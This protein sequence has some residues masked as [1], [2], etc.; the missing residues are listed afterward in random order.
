MNELPDPRVLDELVLQPSLQTRSRERYRRALLTTSTIV[1]ARGVAALTSLVTVPLTLGYL[2]AE[3][4][5]LWMTIASLISF[6]I[7]TDLGLGNSLLTAIAKAYGRRDD[8]AAS[9]LIGSATWL[10]V[11][12]GLGVALLFVVAS[13]FINLAAV[14]NIT[15]PV[16]RAEV[17]PAALVFG[18][19]Y[20]VSLPLSTVSQIR[21]GLQE[22]YVDSA[23][24]AAGN[25]LGLGLILLVI[26]LQLGLPYLVL[27]FMGAPLIMQVANGLMLFRGERRFLAP[28]PSQFDGRTSIALLGSGWQFLVLQ[29]AVAGAFYSDSLIAARLLGPSAVAE[30]AVVTRLFLVPAV[31]VAAI[32]A[33]LWPAYGDAHAHGDVDWIKK[34]FARSLFISVAVAFVAAFLLTLFVGPILMWWLG[35]SLAPPTLL[36]AGVAVWTVMNAAGTS[37]AMLL[38]GLHLLRFQ[39]ATAVL[40]AGLNVTLSII[41]AS[42]IGIAGVVFGTIAAYTL[43]TLVPMA[44]YIPIV[45]RRM[46]PQGFKRGSRCS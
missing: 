28:R 17:G 39:M 16:A 2:G 6:L 27:A 25:L 26:A 40:M 30:Y 19:L 18:M 7:F 20:A 31:F 1:G 9:R 34:A 23:F 38:N 41:L 29:V 35:G 44:V 10:L 15:D 14:F 11:M 3:R 21:Y 12:V 46:E 32:T 8:A 37:I 36:V 45:L 33:P 22:G 24:A 42:R 4:Y 5:G 43:A 13:T